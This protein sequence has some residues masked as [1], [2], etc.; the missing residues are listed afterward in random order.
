MS[1]EP[2]DQS[3]CHS[4]PEIEAAVAALRACELIVYPTETFYGIATDP[5]SPRALENLF[6]LKQRE[7]DKPVALIAADAES[8]LALAREVTPA[9]RRLADRFWPGPLTLVLPARDGLAPE[10]VGPGGGVGVR[11]SPH[12]IATALAWNFGH[13]ITATSANLAGEPPARTVA[14]ARAA[15]GSG[16]AVYLDGGTLDAPAPST[17]VEIDERGWKVA[18]AGAIGAGEIEAALSDRIRK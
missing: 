15:L 1:V 13:P 12:P 14:V 11:V 16:I 17:V 9:A 6:A 7:P 18:R 8:A 4:A 3:T 10:L 2:I 5:F